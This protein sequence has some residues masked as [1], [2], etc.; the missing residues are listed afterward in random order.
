MFRHIQGVPWD[1][2]EAG[3][4]RTPGA[5]LVADGE[6]GHGVARRLLVLRARVGVDAKNKIDASRK[7]ATISAVMFSPLVSV[8]MSL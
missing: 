5:E 1:I 3:P 4:K 2:G 6:R 7:V 8:V